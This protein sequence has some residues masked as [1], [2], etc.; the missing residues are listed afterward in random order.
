MDEQ[1]QGT[2]H[3]ANWPKDQLARWAEA[4]QLFSFLFEGQS[5]TPAQVALRFCLS[6]EAVS[7]V[8]PGMMNTMEVTENAAASAMPPLTDAETDRI[9]SIYQDHEFYDRTFQKVKT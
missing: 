9:R 4:P 7:T 1:F 6:F 8:I 5:R 3:R 2:D